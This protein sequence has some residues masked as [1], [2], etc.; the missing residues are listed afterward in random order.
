MGERKKDYKSISSIQ[1]D[2][3]GGGGS[4]S[5]GWLETMS[6]VNKTDRRFSCSRSHVYLPPQTHLF[7]PTQSLKLNFYC[8]NFLAFLF[9]LLMLIL[10]GLYKVRIINV[11]VIVFISLFILLYESNCCHYGAA[12]Q[13]LVAVLQQLQSRMATQ[14]TKASH[15]SNTAV[16]FLYTSSTLNPFTSD[17]LQTLKHLLIKPCYVPHVRALGP[18]T[19]PFFYSL[20]R[21]QDHQTDAVLLTTQ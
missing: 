2:P 17:V 14:L 19:A 20:F 8:L 4:C 15:Q 10:Q 18:L 11:F 16:A 12:I 5:S 13:W 21:T 1:S 7:T 3:R 6:G 9:S